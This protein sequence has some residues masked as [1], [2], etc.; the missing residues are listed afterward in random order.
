MKKANENLT[1]YNK[2]SSRNNSGQ[3]NTQQQ[4]L[5]IYVDEPL[6]S[7]C[8]DIPVEK[9]TLS[10]SLKK[11]EKQTECVSIDESGNV[12][13]LSDKNK[14]DTVE[15]SITNSK[16]QEKS[17]TISESELDSLLDLD[18]PECGDA[19]TSC[20]STD[21]RKDEENHDKKSAESIQQK[22]VNDVKSPPS[23]I[24]TEVSSKESKSKQLPVLLSVGFDF[25]LI[26]NFISI[27]CFIS[28]CLYFYI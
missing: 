14:T 10:F 16:Q 23:Q 12:S 25:D 13:K 2:S 8:R 19:P 28:V 4:E 22:A 21:E 15:P 5:N 6:D 27:M 20:V 11:V 24:I 17:K 18:T 3:A 1:E 7:V 26:K 9:S